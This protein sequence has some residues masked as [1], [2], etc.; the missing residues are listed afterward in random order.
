MFQ[1]DPAGE[2]SNSLHVKRFAAGLEAFGA[3]VDDPAVVQDAV[4]GQDLS[5]RI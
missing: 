1:V 4:R 5:R 2:T 3:L